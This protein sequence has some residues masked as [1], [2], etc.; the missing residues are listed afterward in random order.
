M[1]L[2]RLIY[3]DF[4]A[5]LHAFFNYATP[6]EPIDAGLAKALAEELASAGP[7]IDKEMFRAAANRVKDKTGLKGKNLFHPIR[8]I[9]TGTHEGPELDLIVPAIERAVGLAGLA[10]VLS[11]RD[12]AAAVASRA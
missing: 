12:R 11:C 4:I 10:Q 2:P 5:L 9:L 3:K 8:V 6:T 7:M 1:T